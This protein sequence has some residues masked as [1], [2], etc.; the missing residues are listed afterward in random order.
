MRSGFTLVELLVVISI[1]GVLVGLLL[2]AVQHARESARR[3]QCSHHMRQIGLAMH[4][5]ECRERKF[6]PSHTKKPTEHN[7]LT[8]LLPELEQVALHQQFDFTQHWNKGVNAQAYK[9]EVPVFRCPS[10]P[11]EEP[12]VSDYAANVKIQPAVYNIFVQSG[13]TKKRSLWYNML[14][15]DSVPVR[16]ADVRDGLSNTFLFFEDAG[17]PTGYTQGRPDGSTITG[18]KWADVDSFFYTHSAT[19]TKFINQ[20]N[21]NEIYSFHHNGGTYIYGDASVHFVSENIE[22]DAFFSLFTYNQGD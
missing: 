9:N 10:A 16:A 3:L 22:P 19:G 11:Q 20:N 14:R 1:I 2:P 17:R 18:A 6:P 8:F 12:Y 13:E 15:P 5:Y 21:H 4:Q 7:I